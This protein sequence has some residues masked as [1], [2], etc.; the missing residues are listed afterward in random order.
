MEGSAW[1]Q[2]AH[3]KPTSQNLD[4][5]TP[6]VGDVGHP[7]EFLSGGA[8]L[9]FDNQMPKS[10]IVFDTTYMVVPPVVSTP[11]ETGH[12]EI[13]SQEMTMTCFKRFPM[14]RWRLHGLA[15]KAPT[16]DI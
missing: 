2:Q 1:I 5:G 15:G 3:H 4:V 6:Y 11:L 12:R 14:K 8:S 16:T 10:G 13:P 7:S 9:S